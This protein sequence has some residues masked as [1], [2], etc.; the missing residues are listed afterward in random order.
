MSTK[1]YYSELPEIKFKQTV[2]R[3]DDF[4]VFCRSL[5]SKYTIEELAMALMIVRN[6]SANG[7]KGVN[8]NY[9]GIQADCGRWS[10]LPGNPVATCVKIDSGGVVRR[11]LCFSEDDGYKISLELVAI[12]AKERKM[13][14]AYHY[15][16]SWVGKQDPKKI[17]IDYITRLLNESR[18]TLE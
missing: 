18:K 13:T 5:I 7:K 14:T 8:N 9:A 10:N 11:F 2:K 3:I 4:T 17:E 16:K 15:M 12:K 6:E 1:N